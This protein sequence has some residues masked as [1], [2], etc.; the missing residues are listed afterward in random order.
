MTEIHSALAQPACRRTR[1]PAADR[2]RCVCATGTRRSGKA[3]Y[4]AACESDLQSVRGGRKEDCPPGFEG[5][6]LKTQPDTAAKADL[7]RRAYGTTKSCPDTEPPRRRDRRAGTPRAV[8]R[9][10]QAAPLR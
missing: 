1:P 6:G 8:K 7:I 9:A 4:D 3:N 10:Q 2:S 5:C